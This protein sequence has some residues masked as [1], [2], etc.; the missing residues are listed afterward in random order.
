MTP[1]AHQQEVT[2]YLKD[3]QDSYL[4]IHL[5][6]GSDRTFALQFCTCWCCWHVVLSSRMAHTAR[7]CAGRSVTIAA[8]LGVAKQAT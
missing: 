8:M 7:V 2:H 1:Q 3:M 5:G 6:V 4:C